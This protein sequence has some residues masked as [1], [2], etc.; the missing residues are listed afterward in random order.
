MDMATGLMWMKG[1]SG[2]FGA[3]KKE[4]GNLDWSE[5]LEW[6]EKL[7]YAGHSDW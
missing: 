6:A 5:A 7:E 1:D 3:G 2:F 4:D